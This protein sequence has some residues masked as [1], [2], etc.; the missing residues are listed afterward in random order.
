VCTEIFLLL[1]FVWRR[2][3]SEP[4]GKKGIRHRQRFHPFEKEEILFF[5]RRPS[6]YVLIHSF[7]FRSFSIRSAQTQSEFLMWHFFIIIRRVLIIK[8]DI[9]LLPFFFKMA[10][11][12]LYY[13]LGIVMSKNVGCISIQRR[14][15]IITYK[16]GKQH[17]SPHI[18]RN[19]SEC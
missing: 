12:L 5:F 18:P 4:V 8:F 3:K 1:F 19:S 11:R 17:I 13:L 15:Y 2:E 10:H 6:S 7:Y 9:E 14:E 16:K